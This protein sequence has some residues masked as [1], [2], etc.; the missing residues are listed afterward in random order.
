MFSMHRET[1]E[2][3]G[4]QDF[5]GSGIWAMEY[6]F[7]ENCNFRYYLRDTKSFFA[8]FDKSCFVGGG[9]YK[10]QAAIKMTQ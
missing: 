6:F 8:T 1:G 5:W 7:G 4:V 3:S 9:S 2:K 10:L